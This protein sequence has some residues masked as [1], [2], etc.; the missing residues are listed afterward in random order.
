MGAAEEV[1]P[2]EVTGPVEEMV[3]IVGVGSARLTVVDVVVA[4]VVAAGFVIEVVVTGIGGPLGGAPP[5]GTGEAGGVPPACD[6]T[7][8]SNGCLLCA[9]V[10]PC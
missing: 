4:I 8:V 5:R 9:A 6:F 1:R 2:A 7:A 3:L 10:P